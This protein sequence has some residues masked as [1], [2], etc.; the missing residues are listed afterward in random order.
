VDEERKSIIRKVVALLQKTEER[1]C[2]EDES[3]AAAAKAAELMA[4]YELSRADVNS[5][6]DDKYGKRARP[7]GTGSSRRR[8]FH[9]VRYVVGRIAK[10]CDCIAWTDDDELVYFGS[11][12]DTELAHRLT[13]LIRVAMDRAFATYLRSAERPTYVHGRSLRAAYMKGMADRIARRMT[14][15]KKAQRDM[16]KSTTKGQAIVL[17]KDRIVAE[18]LEASGIKLYKER[19]RPTQFSILA[20]QA[21]DHGHVAGA[22]VPLSPEVQDGEPKRRIAAR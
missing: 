18:R 21:Y 13:D 16:M 5:V 10:F 6:T 15:I 8:S 14:E 9:E 11:Q 3:M 1:G 2:T 22:T 4:E 7:F 20:E 17:A 19:S 12:T